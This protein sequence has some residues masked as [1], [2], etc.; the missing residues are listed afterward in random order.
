M[1][2]RKNTRLVT[3]PPDELIKKAL[4]RLM[5]LDL[6]E[7]AFHLE[8]ARSIYRKFPELVTASEF[9][10][11]LRVAFVE[12][13]DREPSE[14]CDMCGEEALEPGH[15]DSLLSDAV[16]IARKWIQ[17]ECEETRDAKFLRRLGIAV[18]GPGAS[19][20]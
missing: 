17:R 3:E 19:H 13:Y 11:H 14:D 10:E 16:E 2:I 9:P 20:V 8:T 1:S 7:F 15:R 12:E 5:N 6:A 4:D 18:D